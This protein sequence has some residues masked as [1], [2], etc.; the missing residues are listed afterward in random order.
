M[1]KL[2]AYTAAKRQEPIPPT[3]SDGNLDRQYSPSRS[4]HQHTVDV[5]TEDTE[6]VRPIGDDIA[7]DTEQDRSSVCVT[8]EDT[9]QVQPVRV[10]I[11]KDTEQARSIVDDTEEGHFVENTGIA[12]TDQ[13]LSVVECIPEDTEQAG[14]AGVHILSDTEFDD[15]ASVGHGKEESK[16][17]SG[18]ANGLDEFDCDSY[19][20]ALRGELLFDKIDPADINVGYGSASDVSSELGTEEELDVPAEPE[21]VYESEVDSDS[22]FDDDSSAFLQDDTNMRQLTATGWDIYDEH[23]SGKCSTYRI[24]NH[25]KI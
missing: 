18:V 10:A 6:Q 9:E 24:A 15:T 8:T 21:S 23:H 17:G 5:T 13:E 14:P 7:E 16:R 12:G 1:G 11:A 22:D 25:I 19:M 2:A 3:T 20:D 4:E